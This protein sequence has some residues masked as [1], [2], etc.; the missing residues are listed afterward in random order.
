MCRT[1][2]ILQSNYIPWKGYF[3]LIASVDAF[4]LYDEAQFTRQDWRNRN[5]IKTPRGLEWLTIPVEQKGRMEKKISEISVLYQAKWPQKHWASI[6]QNYAK[7]PYFKAFKEDFEAFYA[8]I[9]QTNASLSTI[10]YELIQIINKILNIHTPIFHSSD[11]E[12][13]GDRCERLIGL[14]KQMNATDYLSGPAAKSYLNEALFQREKI[15]VHWMDYCNYPEYNQLY[16]PFEHSV[17]VLD[18]IFNTGPEASL[19]LKRN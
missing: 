19:Y 16:P 10:N 14:C 13:K 8:N 1:I 9:S 11:F 3:D 17:T 5:L 18:L 12:I 4:I 6:R 2:A 15:A 7:A